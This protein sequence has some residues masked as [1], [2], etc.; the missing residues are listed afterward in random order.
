METN[1][2]QTMNRGMSRQRLSKVGKNE[3][4][5]KLEMA[6]VMLDK[7]MQGAIE[8]GGRLMLVDPEN[9]FFDAQES[10][11]T[12]ELMGQRC[13]ELAAQSDIVSITYKKESGEE[14]VI[15]VAALKKDVLER[16]HA[17]ITAQKKEGEKNED[18]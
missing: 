16:A 10:N 1:N 8:L 5:K 4:A 2:G 14:T 3:L 7:W 13:R 17:Q 12:L 11:T 15:N 6:R 18:S 9:A